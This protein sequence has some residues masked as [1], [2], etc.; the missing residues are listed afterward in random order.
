MIENRSHL[1]FMYYLYSSIF[2]W[3]IVPEWVLFDIVNKV[4]DRDMQEAS[5]EI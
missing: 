5:T 4:S 3:T 1:I 2:L